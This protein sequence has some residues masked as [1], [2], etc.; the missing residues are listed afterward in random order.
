MLRAYGNQS[1]ILIDH[2]T[3]LETRAL[4][5]ERQ[6]VVPLIARFKNGLNYKFL[7]GRAYTPGDMAKEPIWRGISDLGAE[8][9]AKLPLPNTYRNI[10]TVLQQ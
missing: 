10:W 2:Q 1:S 9:H 6:L 3:E 7:P 8:W 5:A 4:L